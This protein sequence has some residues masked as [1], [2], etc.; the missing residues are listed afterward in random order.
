MLW[1]IEDHLRLSAT[2]CPIMQ[3]IEAQSCWSWR[4]TITCITCMS[5]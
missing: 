5:A 1:V 4:L 3:V 2:K